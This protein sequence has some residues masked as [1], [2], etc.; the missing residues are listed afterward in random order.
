MTQQQ[1]TQNITELS[2]ADKVKL[3]GFNSDK[4]IKDILV[5][6][7]KLSYDYSDKNLSETVYPYLRI[8]KDKYDMDIPLSISG[9]DIVKL[10]N[11]INS[12]IVEVDRS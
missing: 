11:V 1:N 2:M 6:D 7:D 8:L 3:L 10:E 5:I 9:V 12:K 4:F